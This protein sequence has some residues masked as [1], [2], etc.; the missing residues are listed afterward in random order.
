M[1]RYLNVKKDSVRGKSLKSLNY[2]PLVDSSL[3]IKVAVS[4][5]LQPVCLIVEYKASLAPTWSITS[6]EVTVLTHTL[7]HLGT[8]RA[9]GAA[10]AGFTLGLTSEHIVSISGA[11]LTYFHWCPLE[12]IVVGAWL[13]GDGGAGLSGAVHP[14]GT[15]HR[16]LSALRAGV[17]TYPDVRTVCSL[18]T[19]IPFRAWK[20][21]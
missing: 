8:R 12:D 13:A 18:H 17:G 3:T 6:K 15:R 14:E 9:G 21:P 11:V 4:I 2:V 19:V 7:T 5:R 10:P 20:T 16:A 1:T